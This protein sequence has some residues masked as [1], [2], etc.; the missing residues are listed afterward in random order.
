[1][2]TAAITIPERSTIFLLAQ[3]RLLREALARVLDKKNDLAVVGACA[4]SPFS[5][6]QIVEAAPDVLVMDSFTTAGPNREFV[7][8]AQ[9]HVPRLKVVMIGMEADEQAFMYVLRQGA[10]G[11]VLKDASKAFKYFACLTRRPLSACSIFYSMSVA[12]K[13]VFVFSESEAAPAMPRTRSMTSARL[14][15]SNAT[16]PPTTSLS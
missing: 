6:E 9:R 12:R 7:R 2:S 8:E 13:A 16:R 1:M 14:R 10:L 5:M 11:Y 4:L 15:A 3:N